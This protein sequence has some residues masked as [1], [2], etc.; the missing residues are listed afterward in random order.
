[1]SLKTNS[2]ETIKKENDFKTVFRYGKT[3]KSKNGFV[4]ATYL[5]V[6]HGENKIV[7]SAISISSS[8]G[9]S[10]WRNRFK[11]LVRESIRLEGNVLDEIITRN[12]S[13]LLIVY[14]PNRISQK[15]KRNLFFKEIHQDV[16]NILKSISLII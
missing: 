7:K 8:F 15:N 4:K 11:R 10:V 12:N 14:S 16:H 2:F 6:D 9:N 1:M 3:I 5:F 13:C